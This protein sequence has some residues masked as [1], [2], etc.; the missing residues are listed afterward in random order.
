VPTYVLVI[1][2]RFLWY[3]RYCV[4]RHRATGHTQIGLLLIWSHD[5]VFIV[6]A[7][8]PLHK[9]TDNSDKTT[10]LDTLMFYYY[11]YGRS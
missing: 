6:C 1:V 11:F 4:A 8:R 3:L 10:T 5:R 2:L 9:E 7:N